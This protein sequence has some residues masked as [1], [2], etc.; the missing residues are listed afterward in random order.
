MDAE[1]HQGFWLMV[2]ALAGCSSVVVFAAAAI[3]AYRQLHEARVLRRAQVRPFVVIDF[4]PMPS[5]I[6]NLKISNIGSTMARNIRFT[7]DRPLTTT[8]GDQWNLME[9]QIFRSDIK[10]LAPGRVI[11]FLF[12][13]WIGR[14]EKDDR[15]Q[16]TVEYAGEGRRRFRDPID[17]DLG[18]FRNTRFIRRDGLHEI[19]KQLESLATSLQ[20][21]EAPGG[22]LLTLS[23]HE[24]AEREGEWLRHLERASQVPDA[25]PASE[26]EEAATDGD[27]V[28]N[29]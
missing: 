13:T 6:V 9:L 20:R 4:H 16:V 21:F 3:V 17:L 7:F 15:Y 12:D 8:R 24:L 28:A 2:G 27:Q 18:V 1:H 22:G 26:G 25:Q 5:S 14:D 19:H 11:E 10:S 29:S 23:P